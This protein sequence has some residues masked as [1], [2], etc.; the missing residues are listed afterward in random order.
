MRSGDGVVLTWVHRGDRAPGEALVEAV[1]TAELPEGAGHLFVHGE[2][3]AVRE[4]RRHLRETVGLPRER[5]SISGYW[6]RGDTEDRWQAT[7]R[8]WNAAI[9]AEERIGRAWLAEER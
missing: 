7:K 5:T 6:R 9:E 2:A 4:L 1:R 3:A 8:E